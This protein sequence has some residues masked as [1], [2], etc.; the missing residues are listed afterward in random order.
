V[1]PNLAKNPLG[2]VA[3]A[4]VLVYALA[5]LVTFGTALDTVLRA[6]LVWFLVIYP[7]LVLAV[8]AW[9]I[10]KHPNRLYAPGD[11][12]NDDAFLA[13]TQGQL[14]SVAFLA[15]A[16]ARHEGD[17]AV[18]PSAERDVSE[19]IDTVVRHVRGTSKSQILWV[20]DRPENNVWERKAFVAAGAEIKL[21]L[22]TIQALELLHLQNFD[23]VISDMGRIEGPREG[24]TL[25]DAMRGRGDKTPLVFYSGSNSAAHK[26]E[27]RQHGGQ[28]CTGDPTEL[29]DLVMA[30]I[31]RP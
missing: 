7:V 29:F 30:L 11:F 4:L 9:L 21:A 6:P 1:A 17:G 15:A 10:A 20:D 16:Q 12:R 25:L 24:Y 8:F 13:A 23:L 5:S 22:N 28:G 14:Q 18:L 19:V 3:L 2:I 31:T 27:T 26:E